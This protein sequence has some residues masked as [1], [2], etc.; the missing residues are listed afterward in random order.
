[1]QIIADTACDHLHTARG[2]RDQVTRAAL[3]AL[4][5]AVLA[6][7]DVAVLARARFDAFAP[8]RGT[9]RVGRPL[10]LAWAAWRGRY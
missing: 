9:G 2:L 7:A 4:L 10:R 8:R 1:V 6:D 3:P 5:P